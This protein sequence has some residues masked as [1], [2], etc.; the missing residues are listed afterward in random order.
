LKKLQEY[1]RVIEGE[2]EDA[3][4]NHKEQE[5]GAKNQME[6]FPEIIRKT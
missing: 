5:D 6:K 2:I 4:V 1:L 3:E